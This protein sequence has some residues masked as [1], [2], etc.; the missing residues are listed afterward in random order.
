VCVVPM[1]AAV[2]IAGGGILQCTQ[3]LRQVTWSTGPCTFSSDFK[4]LP[5]VVFDIVIGIDWLESFSP[6]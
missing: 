5:L 3:L 2:Q 4:V 1:S 6:M